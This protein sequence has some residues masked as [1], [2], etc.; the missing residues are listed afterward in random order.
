MYEANEK[1]MNVCL[2]KSV[3]GEH[4]LGNLRN[5]VIGRKEV[6]GTG[7]VRPAMIKP[8]LSPEGRSH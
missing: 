7:R 4:L 1:L 8:T 2:R 5:K 6:M 3:R